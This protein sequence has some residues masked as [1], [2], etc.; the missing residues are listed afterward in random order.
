MPKNVEITSPPPDQR[1]I[2]LDHP[3]NN[4]EKMKVTTNGAA[5]CHKN[6]GATRKPGRLFWKAANTPAEETS[7]YYCDLLWA[8]YMFK[9]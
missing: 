2:L 7:N 3:S 1:S 9:L 8:I 5:G 4:K 6:R